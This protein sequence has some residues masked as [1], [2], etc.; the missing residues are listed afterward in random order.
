MAAP[1][2]AAVL[3]V[4]LA[5]YMRWAQSQLSGPARAEAVA[6]PRPI[7][8][9]KRAV[10]AMDLIAVRMD[11]TVTATSADQSWRGDV[12]ASVRAP[13]SFYFGTSLANARVDAIDLGPLLTGY[14]LTV[15][16]PRRLATEVYTSQEE[17]QVTTGWLRLRSRSGEYHLGLARRGLDDEA[18]RLTLSADDLDYIREQTRQRI[19]ELV[20]AL[21]G[22]RANVSVDFADPAT[23]AASPETPGPFAAPGAP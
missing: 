17:H 3:F 2:C 9:I 4:T 8:E 18:R 10:R 1:L 23:F 16:D 12:A 15:P 11:T 13:A 20:R 5:G 22:P 19:V 14:R 6:P 21:V 7:A